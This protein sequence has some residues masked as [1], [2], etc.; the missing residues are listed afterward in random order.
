M[1]RLS[2]TARRIGVTTVLVAMASLGTITAADASPSGCSL[3]KS[4]QGVTA[5]CTS[6]SGQFRAYTRCRVSLAPDYDR[7]GPWVN[8]GDYS[9]VYCW[10]HKGAFNQGFQVR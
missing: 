8:A 3:Q 2:T 4:D 10:K 7:Y 9:S 5:H 6:G 1:P